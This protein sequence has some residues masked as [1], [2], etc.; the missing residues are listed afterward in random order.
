MA[1]LP[2]GAVTFLFTDIE[3]ST[4]LLKQLRERY[5]EVLG[6]HHRLIRTAFDAHGGH[7]VDTQ[8]DAFFVA[9]ARARDAVLAA[10]EAQLALVEH[11]WP[12]GAAVRVRMGI[13]TGQAAAADGRYTGLAV[14]RAAR[15]CAAGHGGQIL[16][17]QATQTLIEDEEED[18]HVSL[19][20][21]GE[22]RL[23]DLA[24]PV[25]LYQVSAPT[26]PATFPPPRTATGDSAPRRLLASQRGRVLLGL[27]GAVLAAVVAGAVMLSTGATALTVSANAVGVIDPH[28]NRVVA[29]LQVGSQPGPVT[30]GGS[31]VWVANVADRTVSEIDPGRRSLVRSIPLEETPTGIAFGAGAIWLADGRRGDLTRI[32]PQFQALATLHGA[33]GILTGESRDGTVAVGAG[34]V[35]AAYGNYAVARISPTRRP[36]ILGSDV[37]GRSPSSIAVGG[38]SVWVTNRGDNSLSQFKPGTFGDGPVH[39]RPVGRGPSAIALGGGYVWI[40]N[41]LDGTIGR[42]DP[43]SED[44]SVVPS[45]GNQ[46]VALAYGGGAVWVANA[47]D[48]TVS[49]ID[50]ATGTVSRTIQVGNSPAG[51]AFGAGYVWVT[52]QRL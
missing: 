12:D 10:V 51:I 46:P 17:S 5:A 47:G 15:I 33:A 40:A 32:D 1:E 45:V 21:L 9:F 52:V 24:R 18:I 20:D 29:Q 8:G 3:G 39:Q 35:W 19:R 36:Q 37:A 44:Y 34:S 25:R 4:R 43:L 7:E 6:E 50:P 2:G 14:H 49:R 41:L 16:M 26:L 31:S 38:G 13:H 48:G 28:T 11:E 27:A 30:T 22:Q 42:Y 23:K